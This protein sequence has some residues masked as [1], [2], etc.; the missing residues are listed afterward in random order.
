MKHALGALA[1]AALTGA[2]TA[3]EINPLRNACFGET[4]LHTALSLD[5]YIGGT[6]LMPSDSLRF[7]R[8]APVLV[9]GR[10]KQ[11]NR[12]LDFAAV[13]DHVE[14]LGEMY[15]TIFPAAPGYQQETLKALRTLQSLKDKQTWFYEYVVSNTR[16]KNPQHPPFYQEAETTKIGLA[17]RH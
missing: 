1:M 15:S 10:H 16:G 4:H 12:P 13:S 9:N 5:A 6:R 3:E 17:N 2:T 8:G 7:A 11:L 14:Y